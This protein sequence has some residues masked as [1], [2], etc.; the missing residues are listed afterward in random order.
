[1]VRGPG[2]RHPRRSHYRTLPTTY[3]KLSHNTTQQKLG[4][5]KARLFFVVGRGSC[6]SRCLACSWR[7]WFGMSRALRYLLA[8]CWRVLSD[9]LGRFAIMAAVLA[10]FGGICVAS[11]DVRRLCS[12]VR[13][14]PRAVRHLLQHR[15]TPTH[16]TCAP[17]TELSQCDPNWE[18]WL[19]GKQLYTRG[20][21]ITLPEGFMILP[22]RFGASRTPA[23]SGDPTEISAPT[24]RGTGAVGRLISV[25]LPGGR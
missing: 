14:M 4:V 9:C 16:Q 24:G 22:G 6:E 10:R 15:R 17:D 2:P 12:R 1:M 21:S 23:A 5:A 19:F 7:M 11:R 18:M 20:R 13:R 3:R 8:S 25:D